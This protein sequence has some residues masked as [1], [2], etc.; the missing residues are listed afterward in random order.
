MSAR[1]ITRNRSDR[2]ATAATGERT[3]SAGTSAS[4]A[5]R[6][7]SAHAAERAARRGLRRPIIRSVTAA[8]AARARACGTLRPTP[9]APVAA[10]DGCAGALC[11]M[12]CCAGPACVAAITA[13]GS[14]RS[15]PARS[16]VRRA[17]RL[18]A[19]IR[20]SAS[21]A[22]G[23]S[24]THRGS[25]QGDRVSPA[26]C[27]AGYACGSVIWPS[28]RTATRSG[29]AGRSPAPSVGC[30]VARRWLTPRVVSGASVNKSVTSAATA[31]QRRRTTPLA[32]ARVA[33]SPKR[34]AS[35]VSPATRTGSPI[36][37]LT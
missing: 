26:V 22:G 23:G 7:R 10:S 29:C 3:S 34:Y 25:R 5:C 15:G 1:A 18:R 21:L 12:G 17:R 4:G 9:S 11:R 37:S 16:A 14:H 32:G 19:A 13:T 6:S 2:C 30:A 8:I 31:A 35:C 27:P 20:R 24:F 36:W 33:P 28:A